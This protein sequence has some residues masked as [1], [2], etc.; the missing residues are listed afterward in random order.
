MVNN[1]FNRPEY[2]SLIDEFETIAKLE[3]SLGDK[4]AVKNGILEISKGGFLQ[5]PT[6]TIKNIFKGG[7]NREAVTQHLEQLANKTDQI[8]EEL[9]K[10]PENI[11]KSPI[12]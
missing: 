4:L 6:R 8:V 3:T 2:R 9:L 1:I 12:E 5:A 10:D 11:K 7:Y